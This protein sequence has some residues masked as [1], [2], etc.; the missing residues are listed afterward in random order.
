LR[1]CFLFSVLSGRVTNDVVVIP[2]RSLPLVERLVYGLIRVTGV[3]LLEVRPLVVHEALRVLLVH[4]CD[5]PADLLLGVFR[6]GVVLE[7]FLAHLV[8]V[9]G[10]CLD[11]VL[12]DRADAVDHNLVLVKR[13][14]DRDVVVLLLVLVVA[15]D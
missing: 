7:L 10:S 3:L 12:L 2:V 1:I 13:N 5:L 8:R 15:G 11:V 14:H 9:R 4:H 6:D